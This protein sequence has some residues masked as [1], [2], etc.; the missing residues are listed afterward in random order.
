MLEDSNIEADLVTQVQEAIEKKHPLRIVGGDSKAFYG[1]Q[2]EADA[3]NVSE[4]TGVIDYDPA[5]LVITLRAGSKLKEVEALLA[6]NQQ[7]FA[8]EPPCYS[9]DS[10]I[11]G[12]IA[13]GLAGPRRAFSGGPRD[14]LLGVKMIDGRGQVLNFGGRV[15]KNVA[16]FDISRSMVG[17]LGTLGVILEASIRIVPMPA[18][19]M[20]LSFEHEAA[21]DHTHW[22]NTLASRPLP[23][24]ASSWCD[25][26]SH[27]RLSGSEAGLKHAASQLGGEKSE[28]DWRALAIQQH[29]FFSEDKAITR[30]A[31]PATSPH[32][33]VDAP[34]LLEWGGAQRWFCGEI[35][36]SRLRA[37][38]DALNGTV[39]AFR[40]HARGVLKFHTLP[41][42]M[43]GLQRQVKSRFD[44][45]GIF[46]PNR[47]YPGM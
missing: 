11:G 45:H 7:M 36:M 20:T 5:E 31:V 37:Q 12:M 2:S 18:T 9:E 8:F 32:L 14:Y 21:N 24:S 47:M 26:R 29:D 3:I 6:Q 15:I 42:A 43:L 23:L 41:E 10:T 25:G 22:I 17:A 35:K 40:H 19:E 27:L 1:E 33:D 13:S 30:V 34:C 16:G 28:Q 46:N 39:C 44:P 38:V 4:H